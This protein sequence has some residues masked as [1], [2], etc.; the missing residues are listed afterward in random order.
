MNQRD[1]FYAWVAGIIIAL[2]IVL[3]IIGQHEDA[4]TPPLPESAVSAE[5]PGIPEAVDV[6]LPTRETSDLPDAHD[7]PLVS[8]DEHAETHDESGSLSLATAPSAS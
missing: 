7:V 4:D 3:C 6:A 2:M 5:N 8:D 1:Y